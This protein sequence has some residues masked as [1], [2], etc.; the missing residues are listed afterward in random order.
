MAAGA[1][2]GRAM[3]EYGAADELRQAERR[4]QARKRY[5]DRLGASAPDKL[6][7]LDLVP[8]DA[9]ELLDV[10]CCD[11]RFTRLAASRKPSTKGGNALAVKGAHLT[12]KIS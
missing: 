5:A 6:R 2:D 10:G 7:V 4:I 11:G 9:K 1:G 12:R 3:G 8:P